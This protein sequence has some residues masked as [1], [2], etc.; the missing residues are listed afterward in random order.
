MP[1]AR[2]KR[3]T[4]Q[5]EPNDPPA[6]RPKRSRR[7][8]ARYAHEGEDA[9]DEPSIGSTLAAFTAT[10]L[11]QQKQF[12]DALSGKLQPGG[13]E[14]PSASC[15][16]TDADVSGQCVT[17]T[18]ATKPAYTSSATPHPVPG[19][20]TGNELHHAQ[21][22]SLGLP[23]GVLLPL[24]LKEKIWKH[25]F[26]DMFDILYPS[27]AEA[28]NVQPNID[29]ITAKK[30]RTLTRHEWCMAFNIFMGVYIQKH[31]DDIQGL[32]AY[33]SQVQAIMDEGPLN[34]GAGD[35]NFYDV[36]FRQEREYT[37]C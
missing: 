5:A 8:P 35:W 11:E 4:P 2:S 28:Y 34:K 10:M 16:T 24:K 15:T 14:Q 22:Q 3:V 13:V 18:G 32:L 12:L 21:V 9:G 17:P 1:K 27:K 29:P 26:V 23:V 6:P 37:H 7:Q 25:E 30:R 36:R 33:A 19:T 31:P 20:S